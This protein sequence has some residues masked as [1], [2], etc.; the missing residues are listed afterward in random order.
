MPAGSIE[1]NPKGNSI[2]F[3][4]NINNNKNVCRFTFETVEDC[5]IRNSIF[6]NDLC[7]FILETCYFLKQNKFNKIARGN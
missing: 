5:K 1:N 4:A 3:D 6:D 7:C 2:F